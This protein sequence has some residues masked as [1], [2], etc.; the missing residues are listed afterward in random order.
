MNPHSAGSIGNVIG[1]DRTRFPTD[2]TS[3][4][5][6]RN[7]GRRP[8][9]SVSMVSGTNVAWHRIDLSVLYFCASPDVGLHV[10]VGVEFLIVDL[11]P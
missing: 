3:V 8:L 10:A 11:I 9:E 4:N 7:V 2:L 5:S 1:R 6:P